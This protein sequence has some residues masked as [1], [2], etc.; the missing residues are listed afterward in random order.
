MYLSPWLNVQR[1]GQLRQEQPHANCLAKKTAAGSAQ[2]FMW[3]S[4]LLA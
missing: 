2:F 4:P 3:T 1:G